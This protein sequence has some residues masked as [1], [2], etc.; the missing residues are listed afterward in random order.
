MPTLRPLII[1]IALLLLPHIFGCM[2]QIEESDDVGRLL[3]L[4]RPHPRASDVTEHYFV[5]HVGDHKNGYVRSLRQQVDDYV[6]NISHTTFNFWLGDRVQRATVSFRY[7]VTTDGQPVAFSF[8]RERFGLRSRLVGRVR[9]G[10]IELQETLADHTHT[11]TTDWPAGAIIGDAYRQAIMTAPLK[12]GRSFDVDYFCATCLEASR[13]VGNIMALEE[14][15]TLIGRQQAYRVELQHYSQCGVVSKCTDWLC[16]EGFLLRCESESGATVRSSR[17]QATARF[18]PSRTFDAEPSFHSI[19]A[20][21]AIPTEAASVTM[22]I[23]ARDNQDQQDQNNQTKPLDAAAFPRLW[24]QRVVDNGDGTLTVTYSIF[25]DDDHVAAD[26]LATEEEIRAHLRPTRF[27]QSDDPRIIAAARE[28]VGEETD[29]YETAVGIA[30]WVYENIEY[31]PANW[32]SASETIARR[33]AMCTGMSALTA[34]MC[35]A[36]DIPARLVIGLAQA[37]EYMRLP[38][39]A[40]LMLTPPTVMY[41]H[42]WVQ[43][44]V[45]GYWL[46]IDPLGYTPA[47]IILDIGDGMKVPLLP[48]WTDSISIRQVSWMFAESDEEH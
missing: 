28:A 44:N 6:V 36:A 41:A 27:V 12:V 33:E 9:D 48:S 40:P 20:P 15:E 35:R 3:R 18:T 42:T 5:R 19:A 25:T 17:R 22:V 13:T 23:A 26:W 32:L 24:Q 1:V 11:W 16:P 38:V 37:Y 8:E 39:W 31:H 14:V 45:N 46:D 10:I 2:A 34:A 7:I 4:D 47:R 29:P 21:V 43:V 30:K